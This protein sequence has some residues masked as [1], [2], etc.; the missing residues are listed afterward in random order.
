M[1][2]NLKVEM[3]LGGRCDILKESVLDKPLELDYDLGTDGLCLK[4]LVLVM[5]VL[6]PI[7]LLM[8]MLLKTLYLCYTVLPKMRQYLFPWRSCKHNKHIWIGLTLSQNCI[9][10]QN[11]QYSYFVES[12][13]K[14]AILFRRLHYTFN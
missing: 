12:H 7:L 14:L 13:A 10:V 3:Q 6:V 8:T 4:S 2:S 9:S 11:S 5:L 1:V